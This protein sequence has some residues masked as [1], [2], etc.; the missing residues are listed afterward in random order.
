MAKSSPPIK[1]TSPRVRVIYADPELAPVEVQTD[2][3]DMIEW[4][5]TRARQRPPWPAFNDAMFL[6][7]SFIAWHALKR[8]GQT[9]QAWAAWYPTVTEVANLDDEDDAGSEVGSPI[10]PGR[11]PG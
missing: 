8:T 10:L 4:D 3:R 1:L 2:N 6:W 9:E 11:G 7:L 5:F